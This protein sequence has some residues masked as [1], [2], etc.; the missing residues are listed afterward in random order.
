[1][2]LAEGETLIYRGHPSWRSILGFYA[3]GLAATAAVAALAAAASRVIEGE[4]RLSW[5]LV[6]VAFALCVLLVAGIVTRIATEYVI[7][8]R[9]LHIRHGILSR[10]TEECRIERVQNVS[11]FQSPLQR[12]LRV[13]TVDFDVASDERPG[14]FRFGGV[15]DPREVVGAVDRA[16]HAA[17]TGSAAAL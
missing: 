9:R 14:L 5:V 2:E 12:L 16:T 4:V 10:D 15:A 6:A 17:G 1:V 11:T 7:T 13:G 8:D 3:R